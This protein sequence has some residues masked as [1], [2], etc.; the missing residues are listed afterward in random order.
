MFRTA[1][2]GCGAISQT[3]SANLAA[4]KNVTVAGLCDICTERAEALNDKFG[5][6]AAVYDNYITMLDELKPDVLHIC[7]PHYLHCEM[8]CEALKRDINVILEKPVCINLQQLELLKKAEKSSKAKICVSFQN[9]YLAANGAA[10][11]LFESGE[12]GA[13]KFVEG[14]VK[15]HRE[16]PYYTDSHWRGSK[17]TEGGS[18]M[19]NQA[20]HTLDLILWICGMPEKLSATCANHSLKGVIDTEDTAEAYFTFSQGAHGIFYATDAY[21]CDSPIF[22]KIVCENTIMEIKDGSLFIDGEKQIFP[23]VTLNN[24]GKSYW[25]IG[26]AMLFDDFYARLEKGLPSPI[27]IEDASHALKVLL[28]MYSSNGNEIIL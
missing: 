1:I 10:K 18:V 14:S 3:H 13:L 5:F 20:I 27:T 6:N 8:A 12:T 19:I 16:A 2:V 11:K 24:H 15:W 7:T 21:Y 28:A 22:I 23:E 4:M 25:G 17:A 9:R 26:H